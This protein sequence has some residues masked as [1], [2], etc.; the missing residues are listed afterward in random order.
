MENVKQNNENSYIL[1]VNIEADLNG[2]ITIGELINPNYYST[3][4]LNSPKVYS[5]LGTVQTLLLLCLELNIDFSHETREFIDKISKL[6]IKDLEGLKKQELQELQTLLSKLNNEIYITKNSK[7]EPLKN[8]LDGI[9]DKF[10][11]FSLP[12]IKVTKPE[13]AKLLNNKVVNSI[14]K[15]T[16]KL[17]EKQS[18][19]ARIDVGRKDNDKKKA[20][21]PVFV[22]VEFSENEGCAL[23]RPITQFETNMLSAAFTMFISGNLTFSPKHI[24]EMFTGGRAEKSP[25]LLAAIEKSLD[26]LRS[27]FIG[28]NA[29][30]QTKKQNYEI[31][32]E[33]WEDYLLPLRKVKRTF[34]G[35]QQEETAY[36]FI[37]KPAI[38]GY[39][40]DIKQIITCPPQLLQLSN[41]NQELVNL[42]FAVTKRVI[43]ISK[44]T[45]KRNKILVDSILEEANITTDQPTQ[46]KRY[47]RAIE[48]GLELA[49]SQGY[50]LDFIKLTKSADPTGGRPSLNGFE[51]I[52]NKTAKK[53]K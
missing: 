2:S 43:N 14:P 21:K 33:I 10:N 46:R 25:N 5:I 40:Q 49:K 44:G 31:Q 45:L 3:L 17:C 6:L 15:A 12:K 35:K 47:I 39:S 51:I 18:T 36:E 1:G 4:T 37:C 53:K 13:E 50:I 19:V 23:L 27:L 8:L 16:Q 28:F 41:A 30:E 38:F 42:R 11:S 26:R 52:V 24:C 32:K 20:V 22:I 29:T 9:Q 48:K 34:K 7:L